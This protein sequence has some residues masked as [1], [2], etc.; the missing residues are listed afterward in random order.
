MPLAERFCNDRWNVLDSYFEN[1]NLKTKK[2][3]IQVFTTRMN[4]ILKS[5]KIWFKMKM[6]R[7]PLMNQFYSLK[8]NCYGNGSFWSLFR[9]AVSRLINLW[10]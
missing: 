10:Y 4:L 6:H 1:M 3:L 8:N 5:I 2:I 9:G 7:F